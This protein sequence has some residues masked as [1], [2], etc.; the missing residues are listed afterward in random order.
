ML[1]R[2]RVK[3]RMPLREFEGR[4]LKVL[5]GLASLLS[6]PKLPAHLCKSARRGHIPARFAQR[7]IHI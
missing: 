6:Q 3:G 2:Y 7:F 4:A 5:H 1:L